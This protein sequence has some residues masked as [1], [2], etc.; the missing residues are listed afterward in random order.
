MIESDPVITVEASCGETIKQRP[1]EMTDWQLT[2]LLM[3]NGNRTDV[4]PVLVSA[5]RKELLKRE[6]VIR[7]TEEEATE[8]RQRS[9]TY[10]DVAWQGMI[11][12]VYQSIGGSPWTDEFEEA[13]CR[14]H[15]KF[16]SAIDSV[17]KVAE[18]FNKSRLSHPLKPSST[19]KFHSDCGF[20]RLRSL[21]AVWLSR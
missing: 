2:G 10:R 11:E 14:F 6:A 20:R 17:S 21:A 1:S 8:M 7:A 12:A 5:M 4:D 15:V 18:V 9:D 16:D 19:M 13:L 3:Q